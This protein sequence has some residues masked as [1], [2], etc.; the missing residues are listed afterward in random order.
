MSLKTKI[1]LTTALLYAVMV[2][3]ALAKAYGVVVVKR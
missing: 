3:S 1:A 2:A